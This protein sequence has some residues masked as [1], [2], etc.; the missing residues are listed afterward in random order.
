MTTGYLKLRSPAFGH[1]KDE[2]L[3]V[4]LADPRMNQLVNAGLADLVPNPGGSPPS[5]PTPTSASVSQVVGDPALLVAVQAALLAAHDTDTEREA[6]TP[7]RLSDTAL[8]AA[9]GSQFRRRDPAAT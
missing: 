8:R 7:S 9:L 3:A 2:I 1:G 5:L 4:D 6:F